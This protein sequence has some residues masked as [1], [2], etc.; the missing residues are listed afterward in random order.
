[1]DGKQTRTARYYNVCGIGIAIVAVLTY[2]DDELMD[3]AA[4]MG[5]SER[6]ARRQ[7]WATEDVAGEGAKLIKHDATHFFPS[8]P[9]D[10]YRG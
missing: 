9:A 1:M 6:G 3:W 10:K 7:E 4:Y 5:G 8:L 2:F